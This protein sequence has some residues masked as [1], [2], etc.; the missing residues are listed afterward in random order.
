MAQAPVY[1]DRRTHTKVLLDVGIH[2]VK[3]KLT[4]LRLGQLKGCL[5]GE[6]GVAVRTAVWSPYVWEPQTGGT[7]TARLIEMRD[8]L[9]ELRQV[10]VKE[11]MG[12]IEHY[13]IGASIAEETISITIFI[14]DSARHPWHGRCA[15]SL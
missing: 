1:M 10:L 5:D 2:T 6:E 15:E 3:S 13:H 9:K 7:R 11:A 14:F 4:R 12:A 8:D